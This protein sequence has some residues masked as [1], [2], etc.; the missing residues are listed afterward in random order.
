MAKNA[1]PEMTSGLTPSDD[2]VAVLGAV[3]DTPEG[4]IELSGDEAKQLLDQVKAEEE[5]R[6]EKLRDLL[7]DLERKRDADVRVKAMLEQR[8]V[9]DLRQY[10]GMTRLKETKEFPITGDDM[11]RTAPKIHATRTRCD[12]M[13]SRLADILLPNQ[14]Q[15]WGLDCD[16]DPQDPATFPPNPQTGA[17][18]TEDE[19]KAANEESCAK[20]R[21]T[22]KS[23]LGA[24]K[25]PQNG[26]KMIRDACQIGSGLLIGPMA[27]LKKTRKFYET[28]GQAGMQTTQQ[29]T[30]TE[31]PEIWYGNMWM[32]YPDMVESVDKAQ[33]AHYLDLMSPMELQEF[34][35]LP[36]TNKSEIAKLIRIKPDLGQ[37]GL[38]IAYRNE[39]LMRTEPTA[40]RYAV[41]HFTGILSRD[42]LRT[43]GLLDEESSGVDELDDERDLEP[44][45]MAD[46][47]Y[48][49]GYVLK[50]KLSRI[51][52]DFRI[53]YYVFAPFPADDTMFGYSVPYMCRDSQRVVDSSWMITLHN[54]SVSAGPLMFVR[55]G[56][57]S[58]PDQKAAIR[59]PKT[60]VVNDPDTPLNQCIY[61]ETVP[62]N[63]KEAM[64]IL[65]R[66][67]ALLDDEVQLPQ[68]AQGDVNHPVRTA[69]GLAMMMNAQSIVQRRAAAAFDD[70]VML[71]L[72]ERM[73]W[74][75]MLH[76]E[77]KSIKGQYVPKARAQSDLL[78]KDLQ[79]QHLQ[80]FGQITE[81][82]D[83]KIYRK[84]YRWLRAMVGTLDLPI[85]E[86]IV[87][88]QEA[89]RIDEQ[90]KQAPPPPD[91][92]IQAAQIAAESQ[93]ASDA[94]RLQIA[95][96]NNYAVG[97]KAQA[98]MAIAQMQMDADQRLA[99]V[100]LAH[101]GD[102]EKAKQD[103]QE[104]IAGMQTSLEAH[105]LARQEK[106]VEAQ[107]QNEHP[108]RLGPAG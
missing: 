61:V 42:E 62:N 78:V 36:N 27:G 77:D 16:P 45:P 48:C 57:F 91:P 4:E 49:Q 87:N 17:P 13:E 75:N 51:E 67:L 23:Q 72:I 104:L 6:L 59:G 95:E 85:D 106:S 44:L 24:C 25:F 94:V 102:V 52:G 105:K 35:Q 47:W 60:F 99:M 9:E 74:W 15:P 64:A 73:Y 66:A 19:L 54:A 70:D 71:P 107:V 30:E 81:A 46:V 69:S 3:V 83:F 22:I 29:I 96:K 41:W 11:D 37:V 10:D 79:A 97:V 14:D 50:A 56:A 20:M 76:N 53:P 32:F 38:N 43:L 68:F 1:P 26:R 92:R 65:D 28:N 88:E 12:I 31:T 86:L 103:T 39:H 108:L 2:G 58:A 21:A 100:E 18:Y 90:M 8:W 33:H 89:K 5:K 63:T 80:V 7:K 98:D 84:P 93:A 82:P 34:A 101:K 40:N 55:K